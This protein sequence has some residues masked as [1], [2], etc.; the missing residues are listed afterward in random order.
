M[1]KLISILLAAVMVFAFAACGNSS[2]TNGGNDA[3]VTD[4]LEVLTKAWEG[5]PEDEKFPAA[6]GDM[7]TP[8]DNAPGKFDVSDTDNLSYMLSFPAESADLIDSA[9]SLTHMMNMNTFSC[10]AYHLK[11]AADAATLAQALRDSIQSRQWMCGFPDKLVVITINEVV[12]SMYGHEDL[13]NAFRD[14]IT[15]AYTA[16]VINYDEAINF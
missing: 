16:A 2:G 8:V 7:T 1:K 4:P 14:Q 10:G 9:A 11:N 3:A 15:G 5:L 13:I 12:V 6:G